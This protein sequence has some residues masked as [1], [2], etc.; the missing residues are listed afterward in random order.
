MA[1][2]I[3]GSIGGWSPLERGHGEADSIKFSR[4]RAHSGLDQQE[5]IEIHPGTKEDDPIIAENPHVG[6]VPPS[7]NP[8]L[9]PV[10]EHSIHLQGR[11]QGRSSHGDSGKP[12]KSHSWHSMSK[13]KD[14]EA[15][16]GRAGSS[17]R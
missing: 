3:A 8:D 14:I 5:G 10:F 17:Q 6:N 12:R 16:I 2:I 13:D 9:T 1:G 4:S 15:G 11:G 7:Q